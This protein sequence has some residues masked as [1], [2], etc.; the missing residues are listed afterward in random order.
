M[1]GGRPPTAHSPRDVHVAGPFGA[2]ALHES[3]CI[4]IITCNTVLDKELWTS[5]RG[6]VRQRPWMITLGL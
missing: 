3:S 5:L 6:S 4:P 1:V 2:R